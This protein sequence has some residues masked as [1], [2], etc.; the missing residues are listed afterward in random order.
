MAKKSTKASE[1]SASGDTDTREE[2]EVP[3]TDPD[4]VVWPMTRPN[5]KPIICRGAKTDG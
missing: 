5:A 3:E 1:K 2:I 4:P